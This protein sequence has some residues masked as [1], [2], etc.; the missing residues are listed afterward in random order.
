MEWII[1]RLLCNK[2]TTIIGVGCIG[3]SAIGVHMQSMDGMVDIGKAVQ[4]LAMLI[5]SVTNILSRD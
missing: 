4:G 5:G 3:V 2:V 1:K